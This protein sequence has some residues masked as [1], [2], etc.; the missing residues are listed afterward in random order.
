MNDEIKSILLSFIG[1]IHTLLDPASK[2][3][4][5]KLQVSKKISCPGLQG[6]KIEPNISGG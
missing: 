6:E 5:K 1:T 3:N 4:G 2:A